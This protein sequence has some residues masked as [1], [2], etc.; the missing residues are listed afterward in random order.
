MATT[1]TF[2]TLQQD[3]RR[4]L[5]RGTTY[6]SDPVVFEQIPRLINLAERRI[7]RELKVQ[8]FINVVSGTLQSGV[9]VYAK[10]DRWRDTVSIN[11]G[12]GAQNNTRKVLFARAY[13][14]LLSYWP[15][16]T[17]TAQP[18]YYSEYDYTHWLLA[19]T[20]DADYPFEVLYYELPPLLDDVVQTNWLTDYAPQLLLYGTLLEA[21]PFLKNDERI[22]VW[23]TMYDRAAAMLNGED[24]AKILDRSSVRK[25][26]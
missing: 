19:P 7:A 8:G 23:Q 26:T 20:P 25:E 5:E 6:A 17:A 10:P 16:R 2:T 24:L 22:P 9:S 3:V 18:E 15:D 13:E 11:I 4:Y 14:Y 1:M 21:T 12:T